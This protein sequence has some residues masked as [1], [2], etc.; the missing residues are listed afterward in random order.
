MRCTFSIGD[1]TPDQMDNEIAV[2]LERATL[3][4]QPASASPVPSASGG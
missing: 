4:P 1:L 2:A 3:A